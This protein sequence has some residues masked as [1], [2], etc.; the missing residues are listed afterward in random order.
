MKKLLLVLFLLFGTLMFAQSDLEYSK[1]TYLSNT[2]GW[3]PDSKTEYFKYAE[4]NQPS[5]E[6]TYERKNDEWIP[7]TK[8]EY[9]YYGGMPMG[10]EHFVW[11][12][13][14]WVDKQLYEHIYDANGKLI[15]SRWSAKSDNVWIAESQVT[16]FYDDE[17]ETYREHQKYENSEWVNTI[18]EDLTFDENGK[19]TERVVSVWDGSEYNVSSRTRNTYYETG[20]LHEEFV[21]IFVSEIWEQFQM[22]KRSYTEDNQQATYDV[23]NF[24]YTTQSWKPENRNGS[25]F[26]EWGRKFE[27]L[28][29]TYQES[30]SPASLGKTSG[31]E[32]TWIPTWKDV[33]S[34]EV[35]TGIDN[36]TEIV[37]EFHLANNYPNPFN[38][39]TNISFILPSASVVELTIH[40]VTGEAV[41]TLVNEQLAAG[42]YT[43]V[44]DASTLTSG[45]YF[46]KLQTEGFVEIKK[47]MLLK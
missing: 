41:T 15:K 31:T 23:A 26:D 13:G 5:S 24:D 43:R 10:S 17:V 27:T 44:F 32:G 2:E 29:E 3:S 34:Y 40:S 21:D 39:T 9:E 4:T 30:A 37:S 11:A 18:R 38:P 28:W 47:M 7:K 42:T 35:A 6:I 22:I 8:I 46:Y 36:E 19:E 33:Y 16:F 14:Q 20:N 1:I 25:T 12:D 45:M